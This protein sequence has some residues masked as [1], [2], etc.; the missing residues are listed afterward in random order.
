MV[1]FGVCAVRG[2]TVAPFERFRALSQFLSK[3]LV[4][5]SALICN[6]TRGIWFSYEGWN[7][8][9]AVCSLLPR[10]IHLG[11]ASQKKNQ[12]TKTPFLKGTN[13]CGGGGQRKDPL[14]LRAAGCETRGR[15]VRRSRSPPG[16]RLC[17]SPCPLWG[18]G[19]GKCIPARSGRGK[20]GFA[21][22]SS[23]MIDGMCTWHVLLWHTFPPVCPQHPFSVFLATL[24]GT[25]WV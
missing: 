1:Q 19:S 12:K 18:R 22:G 4:P 9:D 6:R 14:S 11:L 25:G 17:C 13:H 15:G 20:D 2:C 10:A 24:G 21:G 23:P 16:S 8:G 7:T 3:P 5:L